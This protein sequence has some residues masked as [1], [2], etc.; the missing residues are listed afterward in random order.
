MLGLIKEADELHAQ[1]NPFLKIVWKNR[2]SVMLTKTL[3]ELSAQSSVA[4]EIMESKN[5]I[6]DYSFD[7]LLFSM[8]LVGEEIKR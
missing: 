3:E 1:K 2:L 5:P 7:F 4:R 6:R 8:M